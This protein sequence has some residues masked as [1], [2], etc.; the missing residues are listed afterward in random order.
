MTMLRF[1]SRR[2]HSEGFMLVAVR[3]IISALAGIAAVHS[4]M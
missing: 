4:P 2:K 1:P 3:W